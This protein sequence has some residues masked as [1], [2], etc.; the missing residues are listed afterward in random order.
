MDNLGA[1]TIFVLV[2]LRILAIPVGVAAFWLVRRMMPVVT[3]ISVAIVGGFIV[4]FFVL[5]AALQVFASQTI[6]FY[7]AAAISL[8]V[9]SALVLVVTYSVK[10]FMQ[11]HAP[12]PDVEDFAVWGES[13]RGRQKNLRRTKRR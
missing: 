11:T 2:G 1:I 3:P 4:G 7:D 13:A 6:A 12:P 9:S 8:V 5:L 10:R